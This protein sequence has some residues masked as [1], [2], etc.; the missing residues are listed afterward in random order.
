MLATTLA[1]YAF[2]TY[3][4]SPADGK[5]FTQVGEM[6]TFNVSFTTSYSVNSGAQ[7][8]L[9]NEETGDE[10]YST[11]FSDFM[12]MA[13]IIKFD[14]SEITS[15][16]TWTLTIP[17]GTITADG[18]ENPVI[19]ASYTLNDPSL[20]SSS[21]TYPEIKLVSTDPADGARL[22]ALGGSQFPTITTPGTTTGTTHVMKIVTDNDEAVNH[23][24]WSFYDVTD[25]NNPAYVASG[26][27]NRYDPNRFP[28]YTGDTWA[29]GIFCVISHDSDELIEGHKYK[30]ELNFY[31]IGY[32]PATNQYPTPKQLAS[33]LELST[34]L[35][36]EGQTAATVYS[37][38]TVET[39]SPD[40]TN[41]TIESVEFGRFTMTY[42]GPVKPT[43]FIYAQSTGVTPTAGTYTAIEPDEKGYAKVW[44]FVF[45]QSVLENSL[46]YL[47]VTIE[48]QDADGLYVKGNADYDQNNFDYKMAWYCNLGADKITSVSPLDGATVEALSSITVGNDAD[49]VMA[50][51][52]VATEKPYITTMG[53]EAVR[54]LD[55]PVF[56][57]DEKTATWTF[58]PITEDGVY[59]LVIPRQYFNIGEQTNSTTSNATEFRYI[60][61]APHS[62][63]TTD[64]VPSDVNPADG[65]EVETLSTITITFPETAYILA[66]EDTQGYVAANL[67]KVTNDGDEFIETVSPIDN[68]ESNWLNPTIYDYNLTTPLTEAGTYKLVIPEGQYFDDD[69]DQSWFEYGKINPELTYTWVIKGVDTPSADGVVYDLVPVTV[70]PA[71]GAKVEEIS[72]IVVT[73]GE[74]TFPVQDPVTYDMSRPAYLYKVTETG[75]ELVE[76]VYPDD[77][78]LSDWLFPTIYDFNFTK[79]TEAGTYKFVI[80]KGS[81][82]DG[83]Y[84]N[85]DQTEGHTNAELVYTYTIDGGSSALDTIGV[86]EN[87]TYTVYGLDGVLLLNGADKAA[88]SNLNK[89]LYIVNGKKVV[90]R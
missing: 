31:G 3:T 28:G 37:P 81:F 27:D 38:Y 55:E 24:E 70:N 43:Q 7:A 75:D 39:V 56:S 40:P 54:T 32:D 80:T 85:G 89:G 15:N 5:S 78:A 18:E 42:T 22:R 66:D 79:V 44:E 82:G 49:L 2:P 50:L 72:T 84:A 58:D 11:S 35:Y 19:T 12:G 1:A 4:I 10:A 51:T 73:F 71:D 20:S 48:A 77:N 64:L 83:D 16:G 47:N 29:D 33:S 87:E 23:I 21:V 60:V 74:T 53:R 68:I 88:L 34:A 59:I 52:Y 9:F 17:A 8:T 6:V 86:G 26:N 69:Y 90:I 57:A 61:E 45:D 36:F 76:S 25:E 46:G 41:Y 65:S 13:I 14:A 62:G 67:Y 63:V 30:M